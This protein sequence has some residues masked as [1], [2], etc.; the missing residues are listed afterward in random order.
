M[1]VKFFVE[2]DV[3]DGQQEANIVGDWQRID[4]IGSKI[5][6]IEFD[7]DGKMIFTVEREV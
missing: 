3:I 1:Q 4:L 2:W 6:G 7:E 5:V